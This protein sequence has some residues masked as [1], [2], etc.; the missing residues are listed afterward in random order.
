MAVGYVPIRGPWETACYAGFQ[1]TERRVRIPAAVLTLV[2]HVCYLR[3]AAVPTEIVAHALP[4]F[5][6]LYF[7]NL[8]MRLDNG[9]GTLRATHVLKTFTYLE[10]SSER[11]MLYW[12]FK[13]LSS[14]LSHFSEGMQ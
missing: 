6:L 7:S 1:M 8:W 10:D 4:Y 2:Q 9:V 12:I 13:S 3:E 5:P 14:L 11:L